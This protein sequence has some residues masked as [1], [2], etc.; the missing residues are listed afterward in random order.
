MGLHY[1]NYNPRRK[2]AVGRKKIQPSSLEIPGDTPSRSLT[3]KSKDIIQW[4]YEMI[5]EASLSKGSIDDICR[6]Y[7]YSRDM[8]YYYKGK[9]DAQGILGLAD[10]KPGPRTATKRTGDVDRMIIE[11]RFKKPHINMYEIAEQMNKLGIDISA[12][13]VSRTLEEH[14]LS[15]KKTKG[16][17]LKKTSLSQAS[18]KARAEKKKRGS[19]GTGIL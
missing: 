8:Y 16:K 9:F 1:S 17:L 14:G 12:R 18:S 4:R 2:K 19:S 6:K 10:E 3:V 7:H 13:S 5:R 15:L 11:H